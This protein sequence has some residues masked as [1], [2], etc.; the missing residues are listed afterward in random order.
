VLM[1][2]SFTQMMS[3]EDEK[4]RNAMR[5]FTDDEPAY[6]CI[7]ID[8]ES[9][10]LN[11]RD[12]S[13]ES[14]A[15]SLSMRTRRTCNKIT[16]LHGNEL[17]G[18]VEPIVKRWNRGRLKD[19]WNLRWCHYPSC[20]YLNPEGCHLEPHRKVDHVPERTTDQIQMGI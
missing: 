16:V 17:L 18:A 19:D 9:R 10:S 2:W 14:G 6:R 1:I 4:V 11:W 5:R 7:G 8:D 13:G 20:T 15:A 3:S 12:E